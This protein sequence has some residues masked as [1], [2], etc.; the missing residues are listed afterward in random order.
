MENNFETVTKLPEQNETWYDVEQK[1][2]SLFEKIKTIQ[3]VEELSGRYN[4]DKWE[5]VILSWTDNYSPWS[6]SYLTSRRIDKEW[7]EHLFEIR[8]NVSDKW[9]NKEEISYS[10]MTTSNYVNIIKNLKNTG[11]AFN[12]VKIDLVTPKDAIKAILVLEKIINDWVN[13]TLNERLKRIELE[14]K[15]AKLIDKI[16]ADNY[17]YK[18][19]V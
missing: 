10:L 7:I 15:Q 8:R 3:W 11:L 18:N 17:L 1:Y 5:Q 16:D 14:W 2:A 6:D 13:I 9:D 12:W 19:L 4:N